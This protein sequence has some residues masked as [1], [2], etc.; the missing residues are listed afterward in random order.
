MRLLFVFQ[1]PG[2]VRYFEAPLTLMAERGHDLHVVLERGR[3]RVPGQLR[4][5]RD[6][7]E[8][9]RNVVL[10]EGRGSSEPSPAARQLRAALDHLHYLQPAFD[11]SPEFRARAEGSAPE[12]VVRVA[13]HAGLRE[14]LH[15]VLA[16]VERAL[17]IRVD[18][19]E[20][21]E[22]LRPDAV[23]V[24]PYV[25]FAAPQTDWV[26]A[27]KRRG[28][29]SIACAFSWD[30]L[31]SKGALRE[32]PEMMTVWNEA[33]REEA[34]TLH[35]MPRDRVVVT[36][37]QNWDHWFDWRPSRSRED[38]CREVGIAPDRP[39]VVWLESSGYVGGEESFLGE[40][41]ARIRADGG[42]RTRDAGVVVRPHPQ[43]AAERWREA[44]LEQYGNVVVWPR[45]GEVP[46]D[47]PSR[48]R[49]FD[50]LY[51]CSAVV[52]VNT[53]AFIESAIIGRP[54]LSLS[55]AHE[56][57]PR[58]SVNTIHFHHLLSRNGG[59]LTLA[60]SFEE[61]LE[62]L[63]QALCDPETAAREGHRFVERFVR[64]FGRDTPAAPL[65]V[66]SIEALVVRTA[67]VPQREPRL[68]GRVLAILAERQTATR[69]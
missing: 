40:W 20:I 6:L 67:P 53:S 55:I 60:Q 21:L 13:R 44:A 10:H 34:A 41:L 15:R 28:I 2:R 1:D 57:F 36:G 64:P 49:F 30:N 4:F 42:E 37:A 9:Y 31:T 12:F 29:H 25:W 5:I 7:T 14:T 23:L 68:L 46:L 33:Q 51:H 48:A 3:E 43:I 11:A 17:P 16:A 27:A 56:R 66:E 8:R 39:F 65:L 47:E 45:E 38:F 62:Q 61:H 18:V 19:A 32:V 35:R 24:T 22:Q 59:P 52:G 50:T 26:R 54:C 58:G 69:K 63:E